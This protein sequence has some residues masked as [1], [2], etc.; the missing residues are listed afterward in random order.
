M[1]VLFLGNGRVGAELLRWLRKNDEL[2]GVVLHPSKRRGYG[3][4]LLRAARLPRSRIFSAEALKDPATLERIR[5]LEA[6]V[7]VSVFFGYILQPSFLSLFPRGVVNLHPAYL[8]YN[9]GAYPNVWS[10]VDGTPAGAT[11]HLVDAGV[12]TGPVLAQAEIPV[13]PVDTGETLYR[14]LERACVRVFR[15]AWPRFRSGQ[16][17]PQPQRGEFTHHRVADVDALDQI[18]LERTYRARDLLNVLRARTFPP[19][20]GAY[21]VDSDGRRV[22]L[23][24]QLDYAPKRRAPK[25]A[26][27]RF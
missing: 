6:D 4:E 3:P 20:R 14:K 10:I 7:A 12:D 2:V 19:H 17:V 9:R 1:K 26:S 23:R 16:L 27:Q 13:E 5:R 8:P 15:K 22:Y 24:L 18:D 21:F 25:G 11:L